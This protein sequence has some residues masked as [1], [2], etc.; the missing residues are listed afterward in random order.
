[1]GTTTNRSTGADAFATVELT[2]VDWSIKNDTNAFEQLANKNHYGDVFESSHM[3]A[4]YI[5][6]NQLHWYLLAKIDGS[7]FPFV[8]FEIVRNN[9]ENTALVCIQENDKGV[10]PNSKPCTKQMT[11]MK[12]LC[13][14]IDITRNQMGRQYNPDTQSS[15]HFCNAVL[16]SFSL[17]FFETN[18]DGSDFDAL[19]V[20][21]ESLSNRL[22]I[23]N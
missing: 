18:S 10:P 13:S 11:T 17:P 3:Y 7:G 21:T 8:T 4:I 6:R 14:I 19:N 23:E 9:D 5:N 2:K 20:V 16:G 15:Q 1:M 22:I 12:E